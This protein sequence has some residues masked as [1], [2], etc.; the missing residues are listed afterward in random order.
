MESNKSSEYIRV[1]QPLFLRRKLL[2]TAVDS[3]EILRFFENYK[4]IKEKKVSQIKKLK[5]LMRKIKREITKLNKE[6]PES[7]KDSLQ[8]NKTKLKELPKQ[9]KKVR[10]LDEEL[11]RIKEKLSNLSI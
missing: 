1:E 7:K 11:D 8:K 3:T 10:S 5:T 9:T 6:M 4:L 2:E